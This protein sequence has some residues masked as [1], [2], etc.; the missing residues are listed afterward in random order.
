MPWGTDGTRVLKGPSV[1]TEHWDAWCDRNVG[2]WNVEVIQ[3]NFICL[4]SI[5][6]LWILCVCVCM[7]A[8]SVT[9]AVSDSLRPMHCNPTRLLCPW[10]FS[11]KSSGVGY[12]ALL[13]GSSWPKVRIYVSWI[14]GEFF[15]PLRGCSCEQWMVL[16]CLASRGEEFNSGPESRLDHSELL[17]STVL[18]KYQRD[19]ESFLHRHQKGTERVTLASL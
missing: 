6:S 12:H 4:L 14:A 11:S 16:G 2:K 18:L 7:C 9:S 8:S 5:F 3:R 15:L 10:D 1:W 17:C 13:L 19:R